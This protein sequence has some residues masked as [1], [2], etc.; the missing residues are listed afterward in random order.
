MKKDGRRMKKHFF[1]I[2]KRFV[3][4]E[5]VKK[6]KKYIIEKFIIFIIFYFCGLQLC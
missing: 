4:Y 1:K 5:F 6:K 3:T 2:A